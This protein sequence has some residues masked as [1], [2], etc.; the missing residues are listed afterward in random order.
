MSA[1]IL[2]IDDEDAIVDLVRRTFTQAG[3]AVST[4]STGKRALELARREKP[5][6]IVLDI[7]LPDLSGTEVCRTLRQEARFART[8]ILMLTGLADEADKVEAF[9]AGADDYVTKPFSPREILLR[10]RAIV[11]RADP[12]AE[13]EHLRL[14]NMEIDVPGQR[15]LVAK[16]AVD[17]TAIEFKLLVHLVSR[18]GRV[19][20]RETLLDEVWGIQAEVFTR[21]VDAHVANLRKKLGPFGAAIETVRGGGYRISDLRA[22]K[23]A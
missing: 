7:R 21:T 18:P 17:L 13:G 22:A 15:V 1:R 20:S 12:S 10:V 14:G 9:D 16:K 19:Q 2:V 8:G 4:G 23:R 11:R 5:D 6:L 3:Y